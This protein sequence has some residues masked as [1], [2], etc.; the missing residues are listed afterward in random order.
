[1]ALAFVER[2]GSVGVI[3]RASASST[4]FI[5]FGHLLHANVSSRE[6]RAAAHVYG[7]IIALVQ[8]A[9]D[10][11]LGKAHERVARPFEKRREEL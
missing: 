6:M 11:E 3:S 2:K 8:R 5:H 4:C 1:M 9:R 7:D 10:S